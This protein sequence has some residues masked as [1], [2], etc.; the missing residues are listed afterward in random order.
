MV[1]PGGEP[2]S[3]G[4]LCVSALLVQRVKERILWRASRHVLSLDLLIHP[5]FVEAIGMANSYYAKQ[6]VT[7]ALLDGMPDVEIRNSLGV[8]AIAPPDF[9]D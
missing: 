8:C 4:T 3:S 6:L 2:S 9:E 7:H 5:S 1:D